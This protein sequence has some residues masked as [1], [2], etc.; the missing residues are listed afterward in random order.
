MNT[1]IF[2]TIGSTHK[3]CQDYALCA[4]GEA[5]YAIISDGCSAAPDADFGSRL[6]AKSA[7]LDVYRYNRYCFDDAELMLRGISMTAD[8]YRR[9]LSL[10]E[11]SLCATLMIAKVEDKTFRV[12]MVGDGVI[13]AKH[14]DG[15]IHVQEF[16]FEQGA[17]YY[18][19]YELDQEVKLGY[20][21]KFG[22]EKKVACSN[23]SY[24]VNPNGKIV[25]ENKLNFDFTKDRIHFDVE[26]PL[27]DFEAIAIMSDGAS[28]FLQQSV[29]NTSKQSLSVPISELIGELF[30]FK[31]YAGTFVQRRCQ[32]AFKKF[33]DQGL[34]NYD[35]FSIGVIASQS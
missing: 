22:V 1:D 8:A 32:K 29:T 31:G 21:E 26:Y 4:N 33:R 34:N 19:R 2:F 23:L 3:I 15:R 7:A 9:T 17:P 11:D 28:S 10:H 5:P 25:L 14:K 13:A 16:I 6:L 24:W 12:I 30:A 35:D 18:L 20:F 27:E